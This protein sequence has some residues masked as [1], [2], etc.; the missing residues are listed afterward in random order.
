MKTKAQKRSEAKKTAEAAKAKRK[1]LRLAKQSVISNL[2]PT[3]K[4]GKSGV[5]QAKKK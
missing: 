5:P 2:G 4:K 3:T 1:A